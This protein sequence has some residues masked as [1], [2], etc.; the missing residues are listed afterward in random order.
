MSQELSEHY[1]KNELYEL[2]K[3]DSRVFDFIQEGS[4]DGM[5][6]WNI[7][8]I[9]DEWLSPKFWEVLG[10]D[11]K[12]K[13]HLSSAWK[14]IIFKDDLKAATKNF[15]LHLQDPK[16]PYDQIVRYKH[17]NGSTVWIRCRGIAIR[18]AFGNPTRMLG[19]HVDITDLKQK[20]AAFIES[21]E[22]FKIMHNASF[23]GIAVHDKGYILDCNQG[24]SGLTGFTMD[25]LVG[26]NGLLLIAPDYR[27]FVM[28]KIVTGYEKVYEA[29]G[30]RKNG[31]IYPITLEAR[32]IPYQGK[33]VR[34]VEF[35]DITELKLNE[36]RLLES[37]SRFR[38]TVKSLEAGVVIHAT[39]SSIIDWNDRALEILGLDKNQLLGRTATDPRWLFVDENQKPLPLGLYPI[40][41][42]LATIKP[43]ANYIIGV[44]HPTKEI[45]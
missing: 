36:Y 18:D 21:E 11:P 1:L 33:Q 13:P 23:G 25:E 29:F 12:D 32:N 22:R 42:V 30:I 14:D 9:E 15:K 4:L 39:D 27:D 6:Y 38:V 31:E 41:L 35:R 43:I 17:K 10:Y 26:M 37:E 7:E 3:T 16:H 20:E 5:W 40:S 2:I 19:A 34:T 44:V 28:N 45:V 24:L 8:N